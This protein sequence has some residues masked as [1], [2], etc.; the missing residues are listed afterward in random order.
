[1]DDNYAML[2]TT[3]QTSMA[4]N[5]PMTNVFLHYAE[6]GF[7]TSSVKN[8]LKLQ[9]SS[10]NNETLYAEISFRDNANVSKVREFK[11]QK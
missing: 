3:N 8:P 2:N 11:K 10:T 6:V 7:A 4:A 9:Q 1:M 5:K